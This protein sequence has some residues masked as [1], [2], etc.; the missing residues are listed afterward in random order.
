GRAHEEKHEYDAAIKVLRR[1]TE[2]RDSPVLRTF[3]GHVYAVSG[4]RAEALQVLASVQADSQ[5]ARV[6]PYYMA[7][8]WTALGERPRALEALEQARRERFYLVAYL[9][10][11]PRLDPLRDDATFQRLL[12]EVGL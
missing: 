7:A 3:L 11:D 5:H 8:L 6:E 4:R 12:E 2:L 10:V 1:A 9:K